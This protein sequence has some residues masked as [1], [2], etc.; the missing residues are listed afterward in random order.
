MRPHGQAE[1]FFCHR[2]GNRK[3][4]LLVAQ[5]CVG[6]LPVRRNRVMNQRADAGIGQRLL[7]RV[8]LR[9]PHHV[10]VPH[11]LG[12]FGHLRQGQAA[13]GQ[14]LL[15]AR[16][17]G[18]AAF[19]PLVQMR[20]LDAQ[21]GGLQRVEPAVVALHLVDVLHPRAVVAQHAEA[22]GQLR[23]VGGDGAAVAQGAQVLAGI[24]APGHGIAVRAQALALVA[25]AVRLRAVFQHAQAVLA[26]N[27][28]NCVHIGGLTVEMHRQDDFGAR[29]DGGLDAR[30]VDVVGALV[31][32]HRHRR[33][34]A[35]A[36]GQPGG[37]VG[38]AGH[39]DFVARPDVH[40]AQGQVQR[41]QAVGHA[42]AV[43]GAAVS[44]IFGF[45][46]VHFRAEDVPAGA[47]DARN[48]FVQFGFSSR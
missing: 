21:D 27:G 14:A 3:V 19:V 4:A 33:R 5:R 34:A 16:G 17:D 48:S 39:D 22:V 6:L 9:V 46:G 8:A 30:R 35:L 1:H 43:G 47:D 38:V 11:R 29:G 7:Q 18:A 26:G 12:P 25:R 42:D 37:D 13:A 45:E 15:V 41:I 31:R 2:F 44:G 28:Q 24:E 36:D 40:G 32:L 20:Q 10:Q 23:V